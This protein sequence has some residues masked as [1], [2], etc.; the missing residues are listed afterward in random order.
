MNARA[1]ST[2]SPAAP[3][4]ALH[5]GRLYVGVLAV[6]LGVY[7]LTTQRG[8]AWQDSGIFQWRILQ[9]DLQGWLGLALSHPLLILLGKAF[10]HLPFGPL[11]WRM[12]LVSAVCGALAVANVAVLVRRLV[13]ARP[14]AAWLAAGLFGLAHTSWWLATICESQMLLAAIFTAELNV[15]VSLL[16]RPRGHL[17][18]LLGALNG[19]GLTAHNLALLAVPV[20]GLVVVGLCWRRRLRWSSMALLVAG[21]LVG[22]SGF[23]ALIVR[24]AS[25]DRLAAAVSSALFGARWRGSVLGGSLRAVAMGAGCVAYNFPNAAL[26]LAVVG[27]AGLRKQPPRALGRALAALAGI[28]LLFAI[29]YRVADQFMFFLPFYAMVAV[30]AGVGY[31]RLA[32]RPWGAGLAAVATASLLVGPILYAVMPVV[33]RAADLPLPGRKDLPFRDPGRY[34]L[35]PWKAAE[36]SAGRFARAALDEAPAGSIVV[37]DSTSLYPLLWTKHAR[38]GSGGA[39]L[40]GPGQALRPGT[41]DVFVVSTLPG[42]CPEWIRQ[43]ASLEKDREDAVLFRVVWR[44]ATQR[45]TVR[46]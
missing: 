37:A 44:P 14:T 1:A 21:W 43:G 10:S 15:L 26:P 25:S 29:R 35:S 23:L 27:L 8:C 12:N 28:Y 36:D 18:I 16:R 42:Y 11:A 34:W 9:F 22:A 20:Y 46:D 30:L 39:S 6:F 19:L 5:A 4:R 45:A 32:A 13:P 17:V 3:E 7:A 40:V 33:A 24:G 31:D 2:S 41:P 38:G